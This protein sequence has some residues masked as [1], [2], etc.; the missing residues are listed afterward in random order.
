MK[1]IRTIIALAALLMITTS[2]T[3]QH[4]AR[5]Y[6]GK[7]KIELPKGEKLIM[8][9]W[10]EANLFYLTEPMDS[11]YTPKK[12]VFRESSNFGVWESEI[13]FIERR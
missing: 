6:G 8:A 5:R 9:T 2:C 1:I 13:T 7:M 11:G 4:M 12:K 3:E 10:K